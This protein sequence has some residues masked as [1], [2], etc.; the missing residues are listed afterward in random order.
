VKSK[1]NSPPSSVHVSSSYKNISN[2][3]QS[4]EYTNS[5][6]Y[7]SSS[8]SPPPLS[9]SVPNIANTNKPNTFFSKSSLSVKKNNDNDGSI[10]SSSLNSFQINKYLTEANFNVNDDSKRFGN[11]ICNKPDKSKNNNK[12]KSRRNKSSDNVETPNISQ[13]NNSTDLQRKSVGI[14][15][16]RT[17]NIDDIKEDEDINTYESNNNNNNN[18]NEDGGVAS[19][20]LLSI[21]PAF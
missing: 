13:F 2:V 5:P 3:P 21:S 9:S 8:S 14:Y 6:S 19:P 20:A 7:L 18:N 4:P 11:D 16:N 10:L 1:L 12:N 17:D 15:Y